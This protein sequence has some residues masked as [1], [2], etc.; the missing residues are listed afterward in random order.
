MVMVMVMVMNC[1][2]PSGGRRTSL[3]KFIGGGDG[4]ESNDGDQ[5]GGK[6]HRVIKLQSWW[7]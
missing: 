5:E 2:R 3:G 1:W 6:H 7:C 4:G